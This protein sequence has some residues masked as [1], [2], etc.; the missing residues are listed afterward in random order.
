MTSLLVCLILSTPATLDVRVDGP[1][2]FRF[3]KEGRAVYAKTARLV[4]KD[5][6]LVHESGA[7]LLPAVRV[8]A[9]GA[10]EVE[11]DGT[12][13]LSH[14][15]SKSRL[16][17]IVLAV[18][19]SE[20]TLPKDGPFL[21]SVDRP[22]LGLPDE[23]GFGTIVM[24]RPAPPQERQGPTPTGPVPV[25]GSGKVPPATQETAIG[26]KPRI[27]VRELTEVEGPKILLGEIAELAGPP[28]VLEEL[29][30]VVVSDTPVVGVNRSITL[31]L[32]TAR[33]RMA[34]LKP[35]N[36]VIQIAPG[37]QA[38]RKAQR[39]PHADFVLTAVLAAVR[40]IGTDAPLQSGPPQPDFLAEPGEVELRAERVVKS[41]NSASVTVAVYI[42]GNRVNSRV[43]T[44]TPES[45]GVRVG[46]TVK[47]LLRAGGA[48]VELTGRARTAGWVGQSVTVVTETGSTHTGVVIG[49]DRVEVKL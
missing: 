5:G 15:G 34:G 28:E 33:M 43:I 27:Q 37:A 26:G 40:D 13:T 20:G 19:S 36:F 17:R 12:L 9:A 31:S 44:L 1:G 39:I 14:A 41:T 32:L 2:L 4:V 11:K 18:F 35:E 23:S 38:Q 29:R 49:R 6:A 10:V 45:E 16:G 42:S 7:G 47:I 22:R 46:A 30:Q 3:S 25:A 8:P 24:G 48:E 21:I